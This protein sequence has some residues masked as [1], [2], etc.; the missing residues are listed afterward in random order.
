MPLQSVI[1]AQNLAIPETLSFIEQIGIEKGVTKT[2][3]IK[4]E[5]MVEERKVDPIP[6]MFHHINKKRA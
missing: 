5:R 6:S 3:R 2:F 4:A 1:R